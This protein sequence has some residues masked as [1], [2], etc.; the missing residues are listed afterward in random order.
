MTSPFHKQS[1]QP[2]LMA[3]VGALPLPPAIG[4]YKIEGLLSKGGMSMLYLGIHPETKELIVIKVLSPAY[5]SNP[6]AVERFLDEAKAIEMSKHPNIVKWYGHGKWEKGL[7]I[8]MEFIRGVSLRQFITQHSFS[9]KRALEVVLQ[10]AYA[11]HH[12]HGLNIAHRDVKP[13]NILIDE[14]GEVKV[15]DFGIAQLH[16]EK[17]KS[18][19]PGPLM[20][21]L[22]YMSPEQKED[23]TKASAASDIY[24]LGV[25]LYEIVLGKLSYG[26][27]ELN[28]LPP[29]LRA[30][31]AKALAVS[32]KERYQDI[33]EFIHA[34]SHYLTSGEL[35]QERP[36]SDQLKE[37]FEALER[38]NQS[39]SFARLPEW[40]T[41]D[42]GFAKARGGDQLGL[43]S[44][45]FTLPDGRYLIVLAPAYTSPIE[46]L[47]GAAHARGL[48]RTLLRAQTPFEPHAFT[49]QVN[50]I[51]ANDTLKMPLAFLL[52]LLDP[53]QDTLTY[54]SAGCDSLL[55]I[56]SGATA[57]RR[58][59]S[60]N[61]F[62][63]AAAGTTFSEVSDSWGVGDLLILHT[64][65]LPEHAPSVTRASFE[66][67]IDAAVEESRLFSTQRQADALLKKL[68]A[69]PSV[70]FVPFAKALIC[71]QRVA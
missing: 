52:L 2:D 48:L 20:G 24:S 1:T 51:L 9:R 63:G 13:E 4:A 69:E 17:G 46:A 16:K 44:D 53:T 55:H 47:V 6:D 32:L 70:A 56:P 18:K 61:P 14:E 54:L 59:S 23:S 67:A 10:V 58:L 19:T 49:Q 22:S 45:F 28:L 50:G 40:P 11:L 8:A 41:V 42:L 65:T 71:V 26:I 39:L 5:I 60:P 31:A 33:S 15:I 3:S 30:I 62:L 7:Y 57:V 12:L 66:R 21:T 25:V 38:A 68:L 43:Y 36:G 29:L 27:V 34:L 64:F 37:V 35:E